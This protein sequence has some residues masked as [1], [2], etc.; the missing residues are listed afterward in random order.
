MITPQDPAFGVRQ[1]HGF[2]D[3]TLIGST[4]FIHVAKHSFSLHEHQAGSVPYFGRKISSELTFLLTKQYILSKRRYINDGK[5]ESIC[6]IDIN[7]FQGVG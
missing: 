2:R 4:E 5:P 3:K 6:S 1:R 7:D